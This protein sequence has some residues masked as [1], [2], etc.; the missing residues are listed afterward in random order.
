MTVAA[1]IKGQGAKEGANTPV[2]ASGAK[3]TELM[4]RLEAE[5]IS[6]VI[7]SDDGST[8][9]GIISATDVVKGLNRQGPSVLDQPVRAL[10]TPD[11][12]CCDVNDPMRKVYELMDR[13]SIRYLPATQNGKL[14]GLVSLLDVVRQQL[15]DAEAEAGALKEYVMG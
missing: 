1:L 5:K 10:M 6:A 15:G 7:V 8:V 9:A 3:I 12:I 14:A 4:A 11:P 13:H 2:I